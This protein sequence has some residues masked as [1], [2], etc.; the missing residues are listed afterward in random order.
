MNA[1][2]YMAEQI[3]R[4]GEALAHF[5]ETTEA[6]QRTW[7]PQITDSVPT[8]SALEL[9]SE[10]IATNRYFAAMLRGE[11]VNRPAG[12]AQGETLHEASEA[13]AH[14][15]ASS[16]ELAAAV[17]N[18][19]DASLHQTYP[20]WRG[21]VLGKHLMI[22][23]YRNMAYHAGQINYIQILSGDAEFHLPPTWY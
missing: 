16:K 23:A 17:R 20:L 2:E 7:K 4:M 3:E 11:E 13:Q 15:I 1:Q 12:G 22:G 19:P 6:S 9:V 21:P 10:C 14:I 18:L 8:R 5:I